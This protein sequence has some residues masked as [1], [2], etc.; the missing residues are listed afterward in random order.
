MTYCIG[1]LLNDGLVM[2]ADTRT[3]AGVDN[4]SSYKK[5]HTLA[6]SSKRQIFAVTSGSLSMSQ[7]VISLIQEGLP[8]GD[9]SELSRTIGSA[10]SMFRVAQMV[11]EAVQ[12]A[13]NTV[14]SALEAINLSSSV[15]LLLGGRIGDQPPALFQIYSAG[16]FIE[17]SVEAPF[18]Q[19][20]E[21]KY[22]KPILDRGIAMDMPLHEA[23]KVAFLSFDS[24]MRSNLGVARPLDLMVMPRAKGSAVLTRRI[25]PDDDY[26]NALS[27]RWSLLLH[28]AT[29]A[30]PN[31]PFMDEKGAARS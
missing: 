3:N 31:P 12:I 17:C 4:F 14:G 7:T 5:L 22:G 9:G 27:L 29:R 8:A 23:V 19:I 21:T 1:L 30:I 16:N 2:M 15:S 6:D 26:F 28:E 24:A 18:L 25:E 11:G 20:G 13:N 10:T